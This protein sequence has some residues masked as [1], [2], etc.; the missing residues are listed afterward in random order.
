LYEG[1]GLPPLEAM[2]KGCPVL[3]SERA[4]L[5]EVLADAALYFNPEDAED[6]LAKAQRLLNDADLRADLIAR[7]LRQAKKYSWWQ[8]AQETLTIYRQVLRV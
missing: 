1:F 6:F 3:C 4:S 2:A 7:G 5:P 8:C